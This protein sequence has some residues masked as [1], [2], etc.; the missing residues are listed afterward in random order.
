MNIPEEDSMEAIVD[1][2]NQKDEGTQPISP[3]DTQ[4]W[5]R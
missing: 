1:V 2:Q 5:E 4:N 3:F